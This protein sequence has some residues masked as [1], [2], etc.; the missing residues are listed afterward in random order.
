VLDPVA[1]KIVTTFKV[2]H[3]PRSIAFL[4]D[5]SRAYVNAENDGAVV[6]VDVKK[7]KMLRAIS[8]GKPG[9]IKPMGLLLSQDGTKLYVSTGRGH[10][11]FTID[12]ATNVVLGSVEVGQRPWGI[13]LSP[14]GKTLYSANGPSNDVSV[15]DLAT[16]TVMRKIKAGTG[17]WGVVAVER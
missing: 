11:V 15:V 5:G 6:V 12:T 3:R 7:H 10:Q 13:C 9:V 4:P 17:P 2:G 16:N 8:L 14:N 1:G